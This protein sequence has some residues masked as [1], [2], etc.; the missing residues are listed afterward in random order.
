MSGIVCTLGAIPRCFMAPSFMR[1]VVTTI[2][3]IAGFLPL[4]WFVVLN[5]NERHFVSQKIAALINKVRR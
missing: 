2:V 5:D 3:T 1:I 4:S